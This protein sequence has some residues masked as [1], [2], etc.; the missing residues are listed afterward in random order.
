MGNPNCNS[1]NCV[2][3]ETQFE[4]EWE[5]FLDEGNA[6][7]FAEEKVST[8][9]CLQAT[10]RNNEKAFCTLMQRLSK[11]DS[12]EDSPLSKYLSPISNWEPQ[13]KVLKR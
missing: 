3:Q 7:Q 10:V 6:S 13:N 1:A 12:L 11:L 2:A 8:Y 4:R 9:H 5:A